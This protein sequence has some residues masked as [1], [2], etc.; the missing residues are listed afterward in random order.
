VLVNGVPIRRDG[1]PVDP[2]AMPG[3]VLRDAA[4]TT[5]S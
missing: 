5:R 2:A 4:S 1:V 3:Q